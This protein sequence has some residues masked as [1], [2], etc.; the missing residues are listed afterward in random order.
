MLADFSSDDAQLGEDGLLVRLVQILPQG[1]AQTILPVDQSGIEPAQ[2]RAAELLRA[3]GARAE[4]GFLGG[5][6]RLDAG[7]RGIRKG[8]DFGFYG[9][10]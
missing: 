8:H 3:R 1:V 6:Q 10:W 2:H 5:G 9:L 7:R 4:P